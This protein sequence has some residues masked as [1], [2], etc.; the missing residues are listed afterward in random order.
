MSLK[1]EEEEITTE[2]QIVSKR[3]QQP[4]QME[5]IIE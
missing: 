1:A 3:N 4:I 5:L 2:G